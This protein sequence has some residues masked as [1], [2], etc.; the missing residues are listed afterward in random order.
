LL[1]GAAILGVLWLILSLDVPSPDL[2]EDLS[3]RTAQYRSA[4][5][6]SHRPAPARTD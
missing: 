5:R 6:R 3:R 4:E 1:Q 2:P